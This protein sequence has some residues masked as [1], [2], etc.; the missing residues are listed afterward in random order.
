MH[1]FRRES[2]TALSTLFNLLNIFV[3]QEFWYFPYDTTENAFADTA[4]A[5]A[6]YDVTYA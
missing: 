6:P 1:A 3:Q 4:Y 5:H 2:T